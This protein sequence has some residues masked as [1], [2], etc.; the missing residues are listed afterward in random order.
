MQEITKSQ[1]DS[2][3]SASTNAYSVVFHPDRYFPELQAQNFSANTY[4]SGSLIE[5]DADVY[6]RLLPE[7][8]GL[9]KA[10]VADE[11]VLPF[12]LIF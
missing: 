1:L 5:L 11:T 8:A 6:E 7:Y 4:N 12:N 3:L 2:V 9:P 10:M